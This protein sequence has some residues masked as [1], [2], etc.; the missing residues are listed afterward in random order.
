MSDPKVDML[1]EAANVTAAIVT[2]NYMGALDA[3]RRLV[4][5]IEAY[6]VPPINPHSL[7]PQDRAEVDAEIDAEVSKT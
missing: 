3:G 6:I 2:G 5:M 1:S 4:A 7:D